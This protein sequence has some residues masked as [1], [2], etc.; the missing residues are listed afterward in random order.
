MGEQPQIIGGR[1][2]VGEI[3]GRGGMGEVFVAKDTQSGL[4]VAIKALKPEVVEEDPSLLERFE[5]EGEALRKLDHPNIVK[6]L[7][8]LEEDDQHYIVMEFVP[9][10]SLHNILRETGQMPLER[11][12]EIALDLADAL[13]RAHRLKIIHRDIK[14]PNV[15]LT[16]EGTPKLTDFG[17]AHLEDRTRMTETG[18][19]IGTYSYLSPEAINADDLDERADI[20]SFGVMIYEMLAG[21]RP[22][23]GDKVPTVLLAIMTEPVPDIT[24][25]RDDLPPAL[26]SLL[27]AMLAKDPTDRLESV[28][29]VGAELEAILRGVRTGTSDELPPRFQ[30]P[31]PSAAAHEKPASSE[32]G[33]SDYLAD[34]ASEVRRPPRR[35]RWRLIMSGLLALV[36]AAG[37]IWFF[38]LRGG[39]EN[40]ILIVEPIASDEIMVL[41]ADLEPVGV[42]ARNVSRF[43]IDDLEQRLEINQP[44]SRIRLREYDAMITSEEEAHA[45]AEA[46][47]ATI[48]IWGDYTDEFAEVTVQLGV[49]NAF[50]LIPFDRELIENTSNVRVRLSDERDQSIAPQVLG[51]L[52]SLQNAAGDGLEIS[53]SFAILDGLDVTGGEILGDGAAP[54]FHRY[55]ATYIAQPEQALQAANATVDVDRGN[56]LSYVTLAS[57][58]VRLGEYDSALRDIETA[59]RL[60]PDEWIMP[61][62][63]RAN[64]ALVRNDMETALEIYDQ[65]VEARPD[66]WFPYNFRGALHYITGD[67]DQSR[68]DYD[69]ALE[70]GPTADF[71]Y[72]FSMMLALREGRLSDAVGYMQTIVT[73]F[74]DTTFSTRMVRALG[75]EDVIFGSI[76]PA[77]GNLLLGQ[78]EATL[79]DIDTALAIDDNMTELYLIKGMALCNL[80]DFEAAEAAYSRG[81]EIDPDLALLY[82]LR[83]DVHLAMGNV[84][85]ALEDTNAAREFNLGEEFDSLLDAGLTGEVTCKNFFD[86]QP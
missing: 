66:E 45:A 23:E 15:L 68:A 30:T 80:D 76:F 34:V 79:E 78:Y 43:I 73:E 31:T 8:S 39:D 57:V 50:P 47:N 36:I 48:I 1:Y 14:P 54:N 46:N 67:Y 62:Y 72:A 19:V 77:V 69:R 7:T 41:V 52:A 38:A 84:A 53:R 49:T 56:P 33:L 83:G 51:T 74:P 11:V 21:R 13:T 5:R 26:V 44:F 18:S 10:G 37:L 4:T 81:I 35:A 40:T 3:V 2:E 63:I 55:F 27:H 9:G 65:I 58:K 64:V 17:V 60:A 71:P 85:A 75:T 12:L 82:A 86:Y 24:Q 32:S 70:L 29:R 25:F 6:M 20:W 22:F 16:E 28:R 59:E 42:E 61:L